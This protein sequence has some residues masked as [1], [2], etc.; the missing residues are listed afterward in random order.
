M[1]MAAAAGEGARARTAD[2]ADVRFS[3]SDLAREFD[4]TPRTLRHY[5][6]EGLIHPERRGSTRLYTSTDRARVQWILRGRSVG[7]S[8][9]DIRELLNL[10]APGKARREQLLLTLT[11]CRAHVAHLQSQRAAIDSTITEIETFCDSVATKLQQM[12]KD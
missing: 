8:L 3:I 10:Y 2:S 7:F 9:T 1:E 5:E 4:I 11:K 12:E 6:E